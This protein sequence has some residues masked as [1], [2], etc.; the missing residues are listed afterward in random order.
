MYNFTLPENEII[1]IQSVL[2]VQGGVIAFPTDTV[3]GIGCDISNKQAIKRIYSIKERPKNKPLILLGS[4]IDYLVPY[5][6]KINITAGKIIE[7]YFPGAVTIVLPKSKLVPAS[8]NSGFDTVGIRVP[9]YIPFIELLNRSVT[10]HVLATTSANI[11]GNKTS[12]SKKEVK[13]SIGNYIDYIL[14]D[15]GFESK[16]LESTVVLVNDDESFKIIRQGAVDIDI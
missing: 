6:S 7:K 1:K 2:T 11:S 13:D 4:K 10:S 12:L 5:V 3:W 8:I 14:D 15:Y 9:D 16:E